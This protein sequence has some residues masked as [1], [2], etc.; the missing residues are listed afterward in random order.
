MG[1]RFNGVFIWHGLAR[2][3]YTSLIPINRDTAKESKD[4]DLA[5]GYL[6]GVLAGGNGVVASGLFSGIYPT[7]GLKLFI[8]IGNGGCLGVFC[9]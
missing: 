8:C 5:L 7:Y 1:G 9:S 3:G 2:S 6:V 4:I